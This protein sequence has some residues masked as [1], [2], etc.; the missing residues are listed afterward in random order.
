MPSTP[1][2]LRPAVPDDARLAGELIYESM[3]SV[4]AYLFGGPTRAKHVLARLFA[5]PGTRFSYTFATVATVEGGVVGLVLAAPIASLLATRRGTLVG[6]YRALGPVGTA[7]VVLRSLWLLR[8]PEGLPDS[9]C[10]A[11]LA[12]LPEY[13]GKGIG[14]QLLAYA[15]SQGAALGYT[16]SS[17]T[18]EI[19]ASRTLRFY[20]L[21]GYCVVRTVPT[22][23]LQRRFGY[24]GVHVL[25][26]DLRPRSA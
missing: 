4:A 11:H 19:G 6:I 14:S 13:R 22:P 10:V 18:V 2:A 25:A 15:E 26:K 16:T 12:V 17:L 5:V 24:R 21:H 20:Q 3:A 9:F 8:V 7:L 23:R 1:A